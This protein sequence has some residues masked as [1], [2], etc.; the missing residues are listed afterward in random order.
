MYIFLDKVSKQDLGNYSCK[1]VNIYGNDVKK[2]SVQVV[3]EITFITEPQDV[4]VTMG[5]RVELNC[6]A[7]G[8]YSAAFSFRDVLSVIYFH[9]VQS[10]LQP[11]LQ[12]KYAMQTGQR[13]YG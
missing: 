6:Q 11:W 13:C 5:G 12:V 10:N 3:G 4:N 1:A 9:T 8:M 2:I 7:Q